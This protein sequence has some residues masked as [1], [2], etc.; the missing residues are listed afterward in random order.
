MGLAKEEIQVAA[1]GSDDHRVVSTAS[2]LQQDDVTIEMT[3]IGEEQ[4]KDPMLVEVIRLLE[5]GV[6]PSDQDRARKL[7]LQEHLFVISNHVLHHLDFKR[8]HHKRVVVPS[9]LRKRIMDLCQ[10]TS[11]AKDSSIL[12]GGGKECLVMPNSL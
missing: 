11:L 10:D 4:R 9:H 3:S 2:L 12:T 7:A 5:D 8:D 1:V 6:L